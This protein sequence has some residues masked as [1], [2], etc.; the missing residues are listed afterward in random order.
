[1]DA[2]VY[3]Q[4]VNAATQ[5]GIQNAAYASTSKQ[6][7]C[8]PL[9]SRRQQ[10]GGE[11]RPLPAILRGAIRLKPRVRQINTQNQRD[12]DVHVI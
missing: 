7:S 8:A 4:I 11:A 5:P 1:M 6:V 2:K 3:E 10:L 12:R 9:A